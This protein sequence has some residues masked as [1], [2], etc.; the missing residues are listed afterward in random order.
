LSTLS[1]YTNELEIDPNLVIYFISANLN[2]NNVNIAPFPSAEAFLNGQFGGHLRWAQGLPP[3]PNIKVSGSMLVGGQ[4]QLNFTDSGSSSQTN[5]VEASTNLVNWVP[6][7][8][9]IGSFII[10]DKAANSF[11]Y[12][13]YRIKSSP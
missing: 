4:F 10:T 5:V 8:T 12:R 3:L 1:D 11:P 6:I 7:Y 13:F 2:T 9:N